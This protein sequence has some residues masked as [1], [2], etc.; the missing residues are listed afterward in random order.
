MNG[1]ENVIETHGLTRYFGSRCVVDML[2]LSVPRGC[3]FGF[4][5]RNGAGKSTTIRMLLGLV[6]PTRGTAS[7]LGYDSTALPTEARARIGYLAE[8]H[9][10]YSWMSVR[11]LQRGVCTASDGWN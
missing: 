8:G 2:D 10:V 5:G 6:A 11:V 9:H 4:L 7:V 3:I 1:N